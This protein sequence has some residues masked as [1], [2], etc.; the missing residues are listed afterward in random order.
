MLIF[1]PLLA[2]AIVA[3]QEKGCE[4]V[5]RFDSPQR[6]VAVVLR[7]TGNFGD[8]DLE[9]LLAENSTSIIRLAPVRRDCWLDFAHVAWSENSRKVAVYVGD[10]LCGDTWVAYDRDQRRF[11]PFTDLAEVMRA[12]LRGTYQ[13]SADRL[14]PFGGDPLRWATS[15]G[16]RGTGTVDPAAQAFRSQ[17]PSKH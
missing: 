16:K 17:L 1:A 2:V 11:L 4:R 3:V 9:L 12:S 15:S 8:S 10:G 14:R 7:E 6:G 13:L 5:Y